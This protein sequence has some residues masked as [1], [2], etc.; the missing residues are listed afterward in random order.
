MK[1]CG[2][3]SAFLYRRQE[4]WRNDSEYEVIGMLREN[5]SPAFI[6]VSRN[7]IAERAYSLYCARGYQDGFDRDD[8]LRAERELKAPP[9]A[10]PSSTRSANGI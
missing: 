8:W 6:I 7:A 2:H 5:E 4:G 1:S 10:R 9:V 3:A